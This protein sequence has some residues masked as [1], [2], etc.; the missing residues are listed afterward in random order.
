[1]STA[2]S[3]ESVYDAMPLFLSQ[4]KEEIQDL[5]N[6]LQPKASNEKDFGMMS[7]LL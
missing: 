5:G 6:H 2:T 7:S 3:A 4:I 1:V